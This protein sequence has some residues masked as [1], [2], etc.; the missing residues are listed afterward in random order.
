MK[1]KF[2]IIKVYCALCVIF[3][4]A[5]VSTGVIGCDSSKVSE[6]Q[7]PQVITPLKVDVPEKPTNWE[8]ASKEDRMGRGTLKIA[9]TKSLNTV[10]FDFPYHGIQHGTLIIRNHPVHGK[11]VLL[12][13]DKGQFLCGIDG[14][15]I[16]VSFDKNNPQTF[17]AL[18]SVDHSTTSIYIDGY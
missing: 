7:Q 13:I 6:K 10:N 5:V 9:Y 15:K 12:S 16:N 8:Y 4:F 17:R 3:L 14:C 18:E 1:K 2:I 11:G